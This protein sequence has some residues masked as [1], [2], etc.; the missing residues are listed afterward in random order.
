MAPRPRPPAA[1]GPRAQDWVALAAATR[2]R[3]GDATDARVLLEEV[4]GRPFA[5]LVAGGPGPSAPELARLDAFVE[6]RRAGEPLQHIAGH[7]GFRTLDLVIDRRGLIPRP[8]T[9]VVTGHALRALDRSRVLAPPGAPRLR[10]LDLGTGSGAIACSLVAEDAD[11]EVVAVDASP[12]AFAL[13]AENRARLAAATAARLDLRAGDWYAPVA[14]ERFDCVVSN[15]PY[16]AGHERDGLD[17]VVRDHDPPLA[18][19]SGPTGLEAIEAV[20]AGAPAALR[21]GGSLVVEIAPHQSAAARSL[22]RRAGAREVE[23]APDLAGRDRVL[24]VRW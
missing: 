13:A 19:F 10:A 15:P 17:P 23:I 9:E 12:D 2:D 22:A 5:A 8:E 4:S 24:V 20:V 18:L 16:L 21:P 7:W 11:V 6:R 3:L 1:T 14:G